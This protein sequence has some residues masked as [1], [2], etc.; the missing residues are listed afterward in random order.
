MKDWYR[1][2]PAAFFADRVTVSSVTGFSPYYLMHGTHPVLPLDLCDISFM[3]HGFTSGMST[4]ELLA[5]RIK[6]IERHDDDVATAASVLKEARFKS[7][8]QFEKRFSNILRYDYFKPGELVIVRN[9]QIFKSL[10]NKHQP[11]YLGPF[12]VDRRTRNGAYVVKELDGT[13]VRQAVA[14]FR[15]FPYVDRNSPLINTISPK[16][17][18][19]FDS[20]EEDEEDN[21]EY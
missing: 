8:A 19:F 6:Q 3:V 20:D 21:W 5:L 18:K 15:L 2:V 12:E 11:R 16:D 1:K 17:D 14:A 4:S 10:N 7:K 9:S 13:I